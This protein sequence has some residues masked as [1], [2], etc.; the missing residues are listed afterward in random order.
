MN[1]ISLAISI[2][3]LLIG[4]I[5]ILGIIW[6]ALYVIKMFV[7]VPERIEQMVW[8]VILILILIA[9]LTLLAGG[10]GGFRGFRLS[11]VTG[12]PIAALSWSPARYYAS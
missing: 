7:P 5:I 3:W 8:I 11:G 9:V 12:G 1:L 2:L 10:G 4:V 6:L